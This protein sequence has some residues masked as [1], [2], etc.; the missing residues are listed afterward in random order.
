MNIYN[1]YF[2]PDYIKNTFDSEFKIETKDVGKNTLL[3][4]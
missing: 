2:T 4:L 1:I 3:L